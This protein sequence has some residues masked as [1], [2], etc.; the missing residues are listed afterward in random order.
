MYSHNLWSGVP[1]PTTQNATHWFWLLDDTQQREIAARLDAT[2]RTALITS[3][4]IDQF[5]VESKV[6]VA[7]PLQDFVQGHYR[8]LF[9][10]GDFV[11][12]VPRD[13]QAVAFGRYELK[14]SASSDPTVFPLLF[15]TQVLLNGTPGRIGLEKIEYPW[16]PGPELLTKATRVMAEPID[17]EGRPR[18]AAVDLATQ[19][20]LR[21][22]YRLSVF[23]PR[24]PA[25]L[26][27]QDYALV[28]RTA[29]G[30]L[31]S[32]SVY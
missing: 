22:L 10:Y 5:M 19:P 24:L 11:F 3:R 30:Q 25:D 18:G 20:A 8:E 21:G 32:E 28:V 7:G 27:W 31:L 29:D 13:S 2:P 4:S 14:E 12:N 15:S 26:P 23:S 9:R 17:R 1:T 6:P 16:T